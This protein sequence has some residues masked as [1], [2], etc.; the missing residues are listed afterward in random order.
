MDVGLLKENLC[1][2]ILLKYVYLIV[3]S[4][5]MWWG[6]LGWWQS[7]CQPSP[8]CL[9]KVSVWFTAKPS[10]CLASV[11]WW[12]SSVEMSQLITHKSQ[13]NS[14]K[15]CLLSTHS[16]HAVK[17]HQVVPDVGDHCNKDPWHWLSWSLSLFETDCRDLASHSS[18]LGCLTNAPR[19]ALCRQNGMS[20]YTLPFLLC[21][22]E[23]SFTLNESCPAFSFTCLEPNV[24]SSPSLINF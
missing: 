14:E 8:L 13:H 24:S 11:Y 19:M 4:H 17:R 16:P 23:K 20:I 21:P 7:S 1:V 9:F 22:A 18:N 3:Y 5:K 12:M 10:Q 6:S 15:K 2:S